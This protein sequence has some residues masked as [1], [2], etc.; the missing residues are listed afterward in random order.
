MNH[1]YLLPTITK[2]SY[3]LCVWPL[4]T[5]IG[6]IC[7]H[8]DLTTWINTFAN[9][10]CT[11]PNIYSKPQ[12]FNRRFWWILIQRISPMKSYRLYISLQN[13][14]RRTKDH[15]PL[16]SLLEQNYVRQIMEK[17]RLLLQFDLAKYNY[18]TASV[19]FRLNFDLLC[20]KIS[21]LSL[22]KIPRYQHYFFIDIGI[23]IWRTQRTS[24]ETPC[25]FKMLM[26]WS[27]LVE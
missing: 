25:W 19:Y 3:V 14:I 8:S 22:H 24:K 1:I 17:V 20:C 7:E 26:V 10:V 15:S 12:Y 4:G 16:E 5:N 6:D 27:G 13:E 11:I 2:T 18:R 23:I 21:F 9:T